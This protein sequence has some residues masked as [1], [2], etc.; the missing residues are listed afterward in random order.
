ML[1]QREYN[2]FNILF[3]LLVRCFSVSVLIG[4]FTRTRQRVSLTPHRALGG[5]GGGGR[6][7]GADLFPCPYP[8][9]VQANP[10]RHQRPATWSRVS[11]QGKSRVTERI[12]KIELSISITVT[13]D[14]C[15]RQ[16]DS[17]RE[18]GRKKEMF[19]LTTHS[20]HFIYGYMAS[21]I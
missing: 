20:T 19:Y 1:K 2:I 13:V 3:L 6:G 7:E 15:V 12:F 17:N 11:R 5:R 16:R 4:G 8:P 10:P 14:A 9:N 18:T 21:D